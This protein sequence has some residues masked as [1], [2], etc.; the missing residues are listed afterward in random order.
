MATCICLGEDTQMQ[1]VLKFGIELP[2]HPMTDQNSLDYLPCTSQSDYFFN[3]I[4]W[5][6]LSFKICYTHF[7]KTGEKNN[8]GNEVP[9]ML[10]KGVSLCCLLPNCVQ[11]KVSSKKWAG[12]QRCAC[13]KQ[14]R[15]LPQIL[16]PSFLLCVSVSVA[17]GLLCVAVYKAICS[18]SDVGTSWTKRDKYPANNSSMKDCRHYTGWVVELF[19]VSGAQVILFMLTE[20]QAVR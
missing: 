13:H 16:S 1:Q 18:A 9:A 8:G 3:S 2:L 14:F 5:I 11:A 7:T 17:V 4:I 19:S 20:Q 12:G 15:K 10:Y 6:L